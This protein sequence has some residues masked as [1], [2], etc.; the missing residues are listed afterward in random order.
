[1]ILLSFFLQFV[2]VVVAVAV[3]VAVAVVVLL[4]L[5]RSVVYNCINNIKL[6]MM[7]PII[8]IPVAE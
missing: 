8:P 7:A 2:V 6:A 3:A 5:P 4:L 1:M